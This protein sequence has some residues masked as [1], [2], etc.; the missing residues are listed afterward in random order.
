M[1][2]NFN[3]TAGIATPLVFTGLGVCMAGSATNTGAGI[4]D[5]AI[6]RGNNKT[7]VNQLKMDHKRTEE[8]LILD[9]KRAAV[10]ELVAESQKVSFFL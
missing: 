3:P 2:P 5:Y 1:K 8:L 7:A 4:S 10:V 9:E 6:G